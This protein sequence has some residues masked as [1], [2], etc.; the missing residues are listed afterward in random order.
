MQLSHVVLPRLYFYARSLA[1]PSRGG[2]ALLPA[3][4][5]VWSLYAEF[6]S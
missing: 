6:Y 3:D 4:W 2:H 5:I 1:D